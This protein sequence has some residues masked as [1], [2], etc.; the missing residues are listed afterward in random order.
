MPYK[1]H[2]MHRAEMKVIAHLSRLAARPLIAYVL[3]NDFVRCTVPLPSNAMT[4]QA[5]V[6]VSCTVE[7]SPMDTLVNNKNRPQESQEIYKTFPGTPKPYMRFSVCLT[8]EGANQAKVEAALTGT[9]DSAFMGGGPCIAAV[10]A[11][12]RVRLPVVFGYPNDAVLSQTRSAIP[13]PVLVSGELGSG[14]EVRA[15]FQSV[16]EAISRLGS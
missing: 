2:S 4:N 7:M 15:N 9:L 3:V 10:H 16:H 12:A 8:E 6:R 5:V 14:N 13:A 11:P 1:H